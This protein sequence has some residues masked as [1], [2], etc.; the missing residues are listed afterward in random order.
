VLN[1]IRRS[2]PWL[3][4]IFADGGHARTKLRGALDKIGRWAGEIVK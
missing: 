2:F 3:R 1:A 4:H